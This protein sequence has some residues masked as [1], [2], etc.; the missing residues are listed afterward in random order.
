MVLT[1]LLTFI[2][3]EQLKIKPIKLD[4]EAIASSNLCERFDE[5]DLKTIGQWV[6]DGYS[7]DKKSREKWE[8]RTQAAMDLAL[9]VYKDKSF[10]WPGSSNVA[11]PLITIAALQFHSRAYPTLISDYDV[12]KCRVVGPDPEGAKTARADRISTYMSWQVLEQDQC[13]EEQKDRLL[14]NLPI[15]GSCFTKSRYD[16]NKGHKVTETVLSQDLVLDYY[17]KSVEACPRKTHK[18]PFFR[19]E[20]Y[21]N[22]KRK[23]FRDVLAEEWYKQPPGNMSSGPNEARKDNRTGQSPPE[24]DSTTPFMGLE[25]HVDM[26]LDGDGYAEPYIITIE[27]TSQAVLR[28]V[29]GFDREEDIQRNE[30]KEIVS[31]SRMEYFTGYQFIP[32]P[33]GGIYGLGFGMLLGPLNESVNSIINQL[34]DCGTMQVTKGGFLSRGVK[35]RGG[36]YTFGPFEWKRVDST[37]D[38]LRK[39]IVPLEVGEPSQVLFSLLSL[40][41]NYVNRVAGTTDP[42]VGESPGQ[43][44]TSGNMQTMVEQGSKIYSAVFKRVW[45]SMKQEFKKDYILNALYMPIRALYGTKGVAMREDFLGNPDEVCPAADP[46]LTSEQQAIQQAMML[47]ANAATTPGYNPDAVERRV[48][49]AMKI[50]N[51]DEVFPGIEAT[52]APKDV[53][54]QIAEM[55]MQVKMATLQQQQQQ[56]VMTMMEEQ[57]I[58]NAEIMKIQAEIIT[59]QQTLEGDVQDRQIGML[60]AMLGTMKTRNDVLIKQIDAAIKLMELKNEQGSIDS[61]NVLRLARAPGD[62]GAAAASSPLQAAAA[63]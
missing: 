33:D 9:Q 27:E 58:N 8:R 55:N 39:G 45:R 31:I 2:M 51:P 59:A 42:M 43:N 63:A 11:F 5:T 61:G 46:N 23:V 48:L 56:F 18:I 54:L 28:I 37:G 26:D 16:A 6:F 13:W 53:K 10:P 36:T 57:R 25:Q 7:R 4:K 30:A 40:L 3:D 62:G 20:I 34:I 41:I 15:I 60:N 22:V 19:N 49:K 52:G 35:I 38:D 29:T 24:G 44:T 47:K 1:L 50:D 12:V 21:S 32:S 14:I 17:A